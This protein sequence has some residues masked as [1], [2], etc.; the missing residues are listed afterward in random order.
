MWETTFVYFFQSFERCDN[1]RFAKHVICYSIARYM[2]FAAFTRIFWW[3]Y[4]IQYSYRCDFPIFTPTNRMI[5]MTRTHCEMLLALL[6]RTKKNARR[7]AMEFYRI[8]CICEDCKMTK[9]FRECTCVYF[10][11]TIKIIAFFPS[12]FAQQW[13][14]WSRK[15]KWIYTVER[16]HYKLVRML[17]MAQPILIHIMVKK[18]FVVRSDGLANE[19]STKHKRQEQAHW[20]E[21]KLAREWRKKSWHWIIF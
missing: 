21:W 13:R 19:R 4:T 10:S 12:L 17:Y 8:C 2:I 14:K 11:M 7:I 6:Q 5:P 16:K 20:S 18:K 3:M 1:F 15:S 9:C